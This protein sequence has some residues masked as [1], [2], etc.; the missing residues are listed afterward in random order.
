MNLEII[1]PLRNPTEVFDK[2]VESLLAQT[3]KNFSV[4]ISD[5]HSNKGQEYIERALDRL[6]EGGVTTQKIKPPVELERVEH[7]NWAHYQSSGDWLKP[8]FAGDW[9]ESCYVARIRKI[10]SDNPS[11]HYIHIPAFSHQFAMAASVVPPA[12]G[13]EGRFRSSVE[14][15]ELLTRDEAEL[16]PSICAVYERTAF[17]ALGGYPPTRSPFTDLF[18]FRMLAAN[19]GVLGLMAPLVHLRSPVDHASSHFPEAKNED[20][21]ERI[22]SHFAFAYYAWT[23]GY[24]LSVSECFRLLTGVLTLRK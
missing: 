24:R 19:F 18:F 15:R 20:L 21:N 11:C 14:M 13:W 5:N 8:L 22:T 9:L 23:E 4:L 6:K 10:I 7:W 16:G 1:I 3:D 12:N 17:F 2:T